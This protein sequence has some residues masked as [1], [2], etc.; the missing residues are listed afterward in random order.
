[1]GKRHQ[2]H[3]QGGVN[4]AVKI[5]NNGLWTITGLPKIDDAALDIKCTYIGSG[6]GNLIVYTVPRATP[7]AAG[8]ASVTVPFSG[9]GFYELTNALPAGTYWSGLQDS[10]SSFAYTL[11]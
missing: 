3:A 1:M 7:G 11:I 8:T 4:R 2:R 6:S 5:F 10:L 9:A